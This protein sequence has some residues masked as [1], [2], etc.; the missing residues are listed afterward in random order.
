VAPTDQGPIELAKLGINRRP[1]Q[2]IETAIEQMQ[3][4]GGGRQAVGDG[5]GAGASG[6]YSPPAPGNIGSGLELLSDPKG[7][8]FRPYLIQVLNAVRRNWYAVLPESARLGMERG[9]VAIQF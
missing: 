6:G 8:D 3:Q 9:R 2:V 1:D 5:V 7:V 4:A